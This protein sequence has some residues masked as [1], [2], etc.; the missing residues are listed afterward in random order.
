M[1]TSVRF[2]GQLFGHLLDGVVG[3]SLEPEVTAVAVFPFT[4]PLLAGRV[5]VFAP[6]TV[7]VLEEL[8]VV[9]VVLERL[10]AEPKVK[11]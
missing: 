11:G 6:D 1:Q 9:F 5:G 3:L 4:L 2:H 10:V 7:A 8:G